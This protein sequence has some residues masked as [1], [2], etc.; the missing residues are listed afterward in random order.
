[1]RAPV[2]TRALTL[3]LLLVSAGLAP[4]GAD[5]AGRR[6]IDLP[7]LLDLPG[8]LAHVRYTPGTL[9]RSAAVQSRF[10]VLA[11][12]FQRTGFRATSI[13]LYVLSPEDWKVAGL[14]TPYG[15]PE[16]LG[17]D[18]M[19]VPG[20][21]DEK[22]V[23]VYRGWLGGE[24]PLPRGAPI[25]V[26]PAEAGALAVADVLTQ[27]EVARLLV[28][29][30]RLEGDRPWI[31]PLVAHLV[32]RLAWDRYEP[33]RMGEIAVVF[34]RLASGAGPAP[35]GGRRAND[36]R[37]ELSQA[38]RWWY[39]ARF[40]R[41]ADKM[42]TQKGPTALWRLLDRAYSGKEPLTEA[43]LLKKFPGL[44]GWLENSFAP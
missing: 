41:G 7:L 9:D 34:D 20:W 4:A 33:G 32:A 19:A 5:V 3:L 28:R 23:E 15:L 36:W 17:T 6:T 38:E 16:A 25:L 12:E 43:L 24:V 10:E 8:D 44:P 35:A 29:R 26:T 30:A 39:D 11:R 18:A 22:L 1:M 27:V 37:E 40:V 42:V 2:S 14:A 31:A 21:A 13:V